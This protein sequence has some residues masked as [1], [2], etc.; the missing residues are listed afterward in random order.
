MTWQNPIWDEGWWRDVADHGGYVWC[1]GLHRLLSQPSHHVFR[2]THG[3]DVQWWTWGLRSCLDGFRFE[4]GRV[5]SVLGKSIWHCSPQDGVV[6]DVVIVVSF[7]L[8]LLAVAWRLMVTGGGSTAGS[9]PRRPASVAAGVTCEPPSSSLFARTL[10]FQGQGQVQGEG[11]S[12][13]V[14]LIAVFFYFSFLPGRHPCLQPQ[15]SSALRPSP[16]CDRVTIMRWLA[17]V[18]GMTGH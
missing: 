11:L 5:S 13:L 16:S 2:L 14:Q 1:P 4:R 12:F 7:W 8:S 10:D 9:V 6:Q 17:A 18:S 3:T 15:P